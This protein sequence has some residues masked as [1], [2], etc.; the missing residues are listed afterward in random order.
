[1]QFNLAS[2]RPD[3]PNLGM[4]A[5]AALSFSAPAFSAP[6]RGHVGGGFS[7]G[8][9]AGGLGAQQSFA[10]PS[11]A[12]GGDDV[13]A[14][15]IFVRGLSWDTNDHTLRQAFEMYGPVSRRAGGWVEGYLRPTG[16]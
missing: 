14:R 11:S 10:P 4:G 1:V 3:Q 5:G 8:F 6:P 13:T 7:G 2:I 16:C 12:G 15:K 9:N